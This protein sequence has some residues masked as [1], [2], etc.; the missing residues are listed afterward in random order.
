[1]TGGQDGVIILKANGEDPSMEDD[2]DTSDPNAVKLMVDYLYNKN[3]AAPKITI[4]KEQANLG[5]K[6][7]NHN[8]HHYNHDHNSPSRETE[9]TLTPEGDR[10]LVMH[11][12]LYALGS[13]YQIK[14][15]KAL[16]AD[17]FSTAAKYAWNHAS[18]LEAIKI[19]YTATPDTDRAMRDVI[20]ATVQDHINILGDRKEFEQT[21]RSIEG[22]AYGLLRGRMRK[23]G[24]YCVVCGTSTV[25]YCATSNCRQ[26]FVACACPS[27]T[28][29]ER[30]EAQSVQ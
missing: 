24:P 29:C 12:R 7:T 23:S 18:F 1:M 11:A 19:V 20:V 16:A 10:N 15:L 30:C 4:T 3:Y 22:L 2:V 14:G 9:S 26:Q 6:K 25:S 8:P 17:K 5:V 27:V 21:V 28:R 13:T